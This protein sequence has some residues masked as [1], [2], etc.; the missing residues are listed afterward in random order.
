MP[1]YFVNRNVGDASVGSAYSRFMELPERLKFGRRR[2]RMT[3]QQVADHFKMARPSVTQWELGT[4]RPDQTK[5]TALAALYDVPLGWLM[6]GKGEVPPNEKVTAA[7]NSKSAPP[8]RKWIQSSAI[9]FYVRDWREFMGVRLP[10]A[11]KAAG[12]DEDEY[13]AHETHPINF[14]LAQI[15]ALADE[16]GVRGDQFWFQ[17]PARRPAPS[18]KNPRKIV[19]RRK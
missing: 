11:A 16:F 1:T 9:K 2:A 8:G 10:A 12:L 17:P 14:T 15:V 7:K 13:Q 4:S 5:F 6:D 19:V 18:I 3:Q